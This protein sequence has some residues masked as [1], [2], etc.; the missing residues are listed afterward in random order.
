MKGV[1]ILKVGEDTQYIPVGC[2]RPSII[3]RIWKGVKRKI[4]KLKEKV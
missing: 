4:N 2:E 1:E 3:S